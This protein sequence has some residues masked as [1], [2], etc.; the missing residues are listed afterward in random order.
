MQQNQ[1]A[2]GG[3]GGGRLAG[4]LQSIP[5]GTR[6]ILFVNI[7]IYLY[8]LFTDSISLNNYSICLYPVT[9]WHQCTVTAPYVCV[10]ELRLARRPTTSLPSPLSSATVKALAHLHFTP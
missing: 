7:F 1:A 3:G 5:L 6:L 8:G 4:F 2:G 9:E 10:V